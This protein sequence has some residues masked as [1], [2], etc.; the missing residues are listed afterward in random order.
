MHSPSCGAPLLSPPP[1][2]DR[3]GTGGRRGCQHGART[4]EI[5]HPPHSVTLRALTSLHTP[6]SVSWTA[7]RLAAPTAAS[8]AQRARPHIPRRPQARTEGRRMNGGPSQSAHRGAWSTARPR[9]GLLEP[10]A[11]ESSPRWAGWDEDPTTP[12]SAGGTQGWVRGAEALRARSNRPRRRRP[13]LAD[14]RD[15]APAGCS[16][17]RLRPA[18][19]GRQLHAALHA[20]PGRHRRGPAGQ[21]WHFAG[22]FDQR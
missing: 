20:G 9:C 7:L 3:A 17:P 2:T 5:A 12:V 1:F 8:G 4:R 15:I 16:P 14:W 13:R 10:R 22:I 11:C 19:S 21:V 18:G 6:V